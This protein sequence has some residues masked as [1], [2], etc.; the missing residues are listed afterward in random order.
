MIVTPLT[1]AEYF[2]DSNLQI[3]LTIEDFEE[4]H[5]VGYNFFLDGE[6][7][8]G[9][10]TLETENRILTTRVESG[11]FEYTIPLC[12]LPELADMEELGTEIGYENLDNYLSYYCALPNIIGNAIG[13]AAEIPLE[14]IT[15]NINF[16][17]KSLGN[18]EEEKKSTIILET[19][20]GT[21]E[22]EIVDTTIEIGEDGRTANIDVKLKKIK[23]TR[24]KPKIVRHIYGLDNSHIADL[25]D[26]EIIYYHQDRLKNTILATDGEGEIKGEFKSLPFGKEIINDDI[27]H[28]F[29]T[30]KELDN[31]NLY[32]FGA[33]YYD[34]NLGRFTSVDPVEKGNP[35]AY[36]DNNPLN[37]VDPD[38][39]EIKWYG[40]LETRANNIGVDLNYLTQINPVLR[41]LSASTELFQFRTPSST[42]ERDALK[43]QNVYARTDI[44]AKESVFR[45]TVFERGMPFTSLV[46]SHEGIHQ[47]HLLTGAKDFGNSLWN[48]LANTQHPELSREEAYNQIFT[49]TE[50]VLTRNENILFTNRMYE[51]GIISETE[52]NN[53][54]AYQERTKIGYVQDLDRI[55]QGFDPQA[56]TDMFNII[57]NYW[58]N[59]EETRLLFEE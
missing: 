53:L 5:L 38:G 7:C 40:D 29:A 17:T 2:E 13:T 50:E 16:I 52:Y 39:R 33:R 31:S 4:L 12:E 51:L 36:V 20:E 14:S 10:I 28:S 19:A 8:N 6:E 49:D 42:A 34:S 41:E 55:L 22:A 15:T 46:I 48:N 24:P 54:L 57:T 43:N 59:Y 1:S 26:K 32:N 35:Y 45:T 3:E 9:I 47:Y 23:F 11:N 25:E 30:G 58:D 44:T 27:K 18:S 56:Q 21:L 37:Y